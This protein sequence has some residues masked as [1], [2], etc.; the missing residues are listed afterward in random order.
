MD[1]LNTRVKRIILWKGDFKQGKMHG[2]GLLRLSNGE[3]FNGE[4]VDGMIDGVGIFFDSNGKETK[5][6]WDHGFFDEAL[7]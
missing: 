7:P 6:R 4:F 5:G 1:G 2:K 3:A